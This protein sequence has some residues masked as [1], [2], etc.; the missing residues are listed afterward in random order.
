[1]ASTYK[2]DNLQSATS[3]QDS[4]NSNKKVKFDLSLV[5]DGPPKIITLPD[6]SFT[7]VGE[8]VSQPLTNKTINGSNNTITNIGDSSLSSGI[9]ATK[10]ADGSVTNS[11]FQRIGSLASN[12][13]GETDVQTITNK[14]FVDSSTLFQDNIDSTKKGQFDLASVT[15]GNIRKYDLPDADTRL[16][17]H[18]N[19]ETLT[20]KTINSDSNTITNISD[21]QIKSAAAIN[22]TKIANGT[23][24]NTKFQY[25][26]NV[27]SDIQNQINTHTHTSSQVGLGNVPNVKQNLSAITNPSTSNDTVEGYSIG[28][29][30]INVSTDEEFV[31]VDDTSG[32]AVWKSTTATGS[33]GGGGGS[34]ISQ[35]DAIVDI[36]GN[37][38]YT[39]IVA[40]FNAG[41]KSVYVRK[42]TYVETADIII[43]NSGVLIGEG[44][45]L[46]NIIF[47]GSFSVKIDG[48]SGTKQTAGT[49]SINTD[50]TTVTGSGTSF[51]SLSIG[52]FILIG[53]NF[54]EIAS[55]V[56]N[57]SLTL[58][59]AFRG[60][61]ISG[62]TYIAQ[63]MRSDI[64][65]R[66][67]TIMS[68]G[69]SGLFVRA[70][71][72][73]VFDRINVIS[74][75]INV[76]MIDCGSNTLQNV[77][78]Y[79]STSYGMQFTNVY[80]VTLSFC[81]IYNSD[82]TGVFCDGTSG[83]LMIIGMVSTNN[84]GDGINL[85]GNISTSSILG[86]Q[87][88]NNNNNGINTEITTVSITV[89]G[90]SVRGNGVNGVDFDGDNNMVLN[91]HIAQNAQ[92]GVK[93]G[94]KSLINNNQI[95]SNGNNGINVV[96]D[97]KSTI[98]GN[99][100]ASNT[101][102]G[103]YCNSPNCSIVSNLVEA[104]TQQGIY[105]NGGTDSVLNGNTINSNLSQGIYLVSAP[106]VIIS[107][108]TTY[109]NTN[110][111][112]INSAS[113][114]CIV[115]SNISYSNSSNGIKVDS[116]SLVITSNR[117]TS[118]GTNGL[119]ISA[120]STNVVINNNLLT[121]NTGSNISDGGTVDS[122]YPRT[123]ANE[124]DSRSATTMKLGSTTATKLELGKSAVTTESKGPL[125][126]LS[127][128][129]V[130]GTSSLGGNTSVTGNISVTGTVDGRSV[131]TDGATLTSHIANTSN[132]HGVTKS[133]VGL[134]NVEN[135]KVNLTATTDPTTSNDSSQGYAVG[136]R[137]VNTTTREEYVCGSASVGAAVW[138]NTTATSGGGSTALSGLTDVQLS[139]I[140]KGNVFTYNGTKWVNLPTGTNGQALITDSTQ[141]TGLKWSDITNSSIAFYAYDPTGEDTYTSTSITVGNSTVTKNSG[142]FSLSS[143]EVTINYTGTFIISFRVTMQAT[144]GSKN[145]Y[146]TSRSWLEL[147][148][149]SSYSE[150]AGTSI[151]TYTTSSGN[152][153]TGG[154]T[155]A[156]NVTTGNKVRVRTACVDGSNTLKTIANGSGITI[157]CI[158]KSA[159]TGSGPKWYGS[160]AT[161]PTGTFNS[162]EQYFNT[163][164][165]QI[166]YYDGI[167]SKWLSTAL[168]SEGSGA[169]GTTAA[170]AFYKRYNSL[171]LS[172]TTGPYVP[173]GTIVAIGFGTNN[174]VTHTLEVLVSG[175]TV[176]SLSS[177]GATSGYSGTINGDFNGGKM[178]TRNATGSASTSNFQGTVW[179]RLRA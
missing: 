31:C 78:S 98:T 82:S 26:S 21:A 70:T 38:N 104:N 135:L 4:N 88:S 34:G 114:D 103:I 139:S 162:G 132:P 57:T 109:S 160:S 94:D 153:Q 89:N 55:I 12:A 87:F 125:T 74:N 39:S 145:S 130:T 91:C 136:S 133:Q 100:V 149:G 36:G 177:G 148:T 50:S 23:V 141:A 102:I 37:G 83:R 29:R 93:A 13:V 99:R 107:N 86:G 165:G 152:S 155:I 8:N 7:M 54:Y 161:D 69:S 151:F 101:G 170:G 119:L 92:Y 6:A 61:T 131:S 112:E 24:S 156:M 71:R 14:T 64:L 30:W 75:N 16:V 67:I 62:Q 142:E 173:K 68:S 128:L 126:A 96:S 19:T 44:S 116:S 2:I 97:Q 43:P 76:T 90:A 159:I 118:N 178:A 134:G 11:E 59:N 10:L 5:S 73:S 77:V 42:G 80:S 110:G 117:C 146:N 65:I 123:L 84:D 46:T 20:N 166:M 15:S 72:L 49:I 17:G 174:A 18:N 3:I 121:G 176:A 138:K 122:T 147:N 63:A 33:G 175:S 95:E 56:S 115:N 53:N 48:S 81:G 171:A 32:S 158:D 85:Y 167:R 120:T 28:S 66:S 25:L 45:G 169:N 47:S 27:T 127:G 157:T 154:C 164:I 40:A 35:Y 106:R 144:T 140:A 111:I 124:F 51:T 172:T 9:D 22:A 168:Y 137:W 60:E 58:V 143:G 179:Y 52:N 1:M 79:N 150:V 41:H 129:S 163:A 113:S 105:L 108:N